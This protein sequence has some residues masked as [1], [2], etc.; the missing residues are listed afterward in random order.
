[1]SAG[2]PTGSEFC[3]RVTSSADESDANLRA[4]AAM[5]PAFSQ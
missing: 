5:R 4:T 1:M 2:S 3:V